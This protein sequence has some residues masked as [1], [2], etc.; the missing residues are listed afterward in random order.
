MCAGI[1]RQIWRQVKYEETVSFFERVSKDRIFLIKKMDSSPREERM[2]SFDEQIRLKIWLQLTPRYS[3]AID[4]EREIIYV[5][6]IKIKWVK[7]T[8]SVESFV[9]DKS[10]DEALSYRSHVDV[11]ESLAVNT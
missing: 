8:V 5:K 4:T 10:T 2:V 11:I 9:S 6:M 1:G 7:P 3:D